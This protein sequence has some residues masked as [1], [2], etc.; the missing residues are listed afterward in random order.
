MN[1]TCF[2][3]E[4]TWTPLYQLRDVGKAGR[5]L[6]I[7]D[8]IVLQLR[9]CCVN[10][11]KFASLLS[12]GER[13]AEK[14]RIQTFSSMTLA[15][16]SRKISVKGREFSG[17]H[18]CHA[19]AITPWFRLTKER[20]PESAPPRQEEGGGSHP[21]QLQQEAQE[22]GK[23][24]WQR[25]EPPEAPHCSCRLKG[26]VHPTLLVFIQNPKPRASLFH[27]EKEQF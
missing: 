16:H 27:K 7:Q 13:A 4:L 12:C 17:S 18:H 20:G 21:A 2:F 19:K 24:R 5:T 14:N 22:P 6:N 11:P 25:W 1:L 15:V 3:P 26:M 23:G 10:S 9:N 8:A